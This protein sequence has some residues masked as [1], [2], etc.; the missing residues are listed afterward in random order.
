MAWN[1]PDG[2]D[3]NRKT[4]DAPTP[5]SLRS[6]L[7]SDAREREKAGQPALPAVLLVFAGPGLSYG[8][9]ARFLAPV[10]PTHGTVYVFEEMPDEPSQRA[11]QREAAK[12]KET[13]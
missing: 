1:D 12:R 13:K 3:A 2:G 11:E 6:A 10:L 4:V 5:G 7:E 8:Q 9:V